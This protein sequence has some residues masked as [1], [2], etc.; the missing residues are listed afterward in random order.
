MLLNES[1]SMEAFIEIDG[2][3]DLAKVLFKHSIIW[4]NAM[5]YLYGKLY[6]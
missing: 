4:D 2:I 3:I 6:K 5:W 1:D